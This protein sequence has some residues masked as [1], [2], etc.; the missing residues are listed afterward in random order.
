MGDKKLRQERDTMLAVMTLVLD[1]KLTN[2]Y[3]EIIKIYH[4]NKAKLQ[5]DIP[6]GDDEVQRIVRDFFTNDNTV[7][8]LV[9]YKDIVNKSKRKGEVPLYQFYLNM[10]PE[11][12]RLAMVEKGKELIELKKDEIVET[13][14]RKT[15]TH[16]PLDEYIC[17]IYTLN[18]MRQQEKIKK[19][20]DEKQK[21]K[22]REYKKEVLAK[23]FGDH[24]DV[25]ALKQ[26][27]E[28][29]KGITLKQR[30]DYKVPKDKWRLGKELK[31]LRAKFPHDRVLQRMVAEEFKTNQPFLYPEEYDI[32]NREREAS[33]KKNFKEG[34]D[35][36]DE[37]KQNWKVPDFANEA[38][39][40]A[41][42]RK[43][44]AFDK[45]D[46]EKKMKNEMLKE[47]KLEKFIWKQALEYQEYMSRRHKGEDKKT[48]REVLARNYQTLVEVHG[49]IAEA[50][51]PHLSY[52]QDK[53]SETFKKSFP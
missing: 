13:E 7:K 11:E 36:Q 3:T 43:R 4:S 20:K 33:L 27:D 39:T 21:L 16:L 10:K 5:Q 26:D 14:G 30:P 37:K 50:R 32:Y 42:F 24:F 47:Q 28:P 2:D 35:H 6:G 19:A 52:G 51:F 25:K 8:R 1:T 48:L 31:Q 22:Q 44:D 34:A 17:H 9:L 29:E 23:V 49:K 12:K 46:L 41:N 18:Q 38:S 53:N 15:R 45:A 40:L